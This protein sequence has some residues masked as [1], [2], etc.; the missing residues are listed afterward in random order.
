MIDAVMVVS[1]LS[2]I[3]IALPALMIGS[4]VG[5]SLLCSLGR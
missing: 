4:L 3:S 2:S 1:W 5:A